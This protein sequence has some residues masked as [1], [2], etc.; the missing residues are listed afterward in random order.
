LGQNL[1]GLPAELVLPLEGL[2][3]PLEEFVRKENS[4]ESA[5]IVQRRLVRL[6]RRRQVHQQVKLA[7]V[8]FAA[9]KD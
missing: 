9:L 5:V 6:V 3:S 1:K 7:A 8:S 2:R 4:E